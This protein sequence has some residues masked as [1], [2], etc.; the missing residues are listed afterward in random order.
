MGVTSWH[1]EVRQRLF[2]FSS[3]PQIFYPNFA[4]AY[5]RL[6][7]MYGTL[8]ESELGAESTARAYELRDRASD[9]ERFFIDASYDSRVTGN[10]E[11]AQQTCEAWAQAYPRASL[12][13]LYLAGF[14]YPASG[15]YVKAVEESRKA[16]EIDPDFAVGYTLLAG[17]SVEL[18]RF[19]DGE[20]ALRR[21]ADRNL[22][23]PEDMVQSFDLAFLKLEKSGNGAGAWIGCWKIRRGLLDV[24]SPGLRFRI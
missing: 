23:T 11:K 15:K 19:K 20:D 6:G 13:H 1:P 7:L 22:D 18:D 4:L 2:P 8:G 5:V 14:I 17:N 12:A 9:E 24:G 10:F 16:I 21:A 3:K